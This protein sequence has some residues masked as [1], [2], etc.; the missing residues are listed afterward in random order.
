MSF[1]DPKKNIQQFGIGED[2]QVADF[3]VGSGAYSLLAARKVGPDGRVYAID[4]QKNLL[5]RV[6]KE[7]EEQGLLNVE[8]IWGD[9]EKTNGSKLKDGSMNSVIATNIL[10]QA[11]DKRR[12]VQEIGRV[13]K[14]GG[15][16]LVVDWTDSFGG[17]G[18]QTDDIISE[19]VARAM[20]EESGLV[21]E[22]KIDA[23]E[24]HYGI[25]FKKS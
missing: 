9:I 6:K 15:R 1:S 11:E 18:P 21:F 24:H 23:G 16:V 17:L 8:I 14:P 2:W 12:V 13:L 19:D 5:E 4:V 7:A 20:F 3:G 22:K 25:T 10:F